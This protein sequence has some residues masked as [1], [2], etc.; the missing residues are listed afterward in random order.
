MIYEFMSIY[1]FNV[2]QKNVAFHSRSQVLLRL[3]YLAGLLNADCPCADHGCGKA[4]NKRTTWGW[5]MQPI[6]DDLGTVDCWVDHILAY[7]LVN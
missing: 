1:V 7:P 6:Y 5:F 3:R 4:T 2:M